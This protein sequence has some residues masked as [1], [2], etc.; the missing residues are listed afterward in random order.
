MEDDSFVLPQDIRFNVF[1]AH[2]I[3]VF[4]GKLACW[5]KF[6]W[7]LTFR[8]ISRIESSSTSVCDYGYTGSLRNHLS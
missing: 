2:M 8:Y 1:Q 6:S 5:K 3:Q 4:A 7:Y